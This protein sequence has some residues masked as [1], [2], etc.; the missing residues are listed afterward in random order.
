MAKRIVTRI[1]NIF[2]AEIDGKYKVYFQYIANDTEALNSSVIRGF[3]RKYPLDYKPN[4][5]EIVKDEVVFYLHT[6]L[7][8]GIENGIWYKVGKSDDLELDKL[9]RIWFALLDSDYYDSEK[10]QIIK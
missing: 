9:N 8:E 5:D 1:G 3:K 6:V 4:I 10:E 7:R 2:C